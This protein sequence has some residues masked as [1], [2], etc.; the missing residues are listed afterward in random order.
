MITR[1]QLQKLYE[2]AIQASEYLMPDGY[3]P[4]GQILNILTTALAAPDEPYGVVLVNTVDQEAVM[5]YS[6]DMVPDKS[7]LKDKFE[8]VPVY[9]QPSKPS[10]E[11]IRGEVA[12]G[13]CTER[14][15]SKP[16]DVE[17]AED[18][19]GAV[20]ERMNGK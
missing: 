13:W 14:N 12:R 3:K 6:P 2:L 16:M 18:I 10:L 20:W 7:T 15:A 1:E 8:L 11:D 9:T 4:Q 17:L 19:A 5:F